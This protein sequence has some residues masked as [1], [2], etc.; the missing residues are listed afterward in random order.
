[1]LSAKNSSWAASW[2]VGSAIVVSA[3]G[4]S[5][6]DAQVLHSYRQLPGYDDWGYIS[7]SEERGYNG[8]NGL[9]DLNGINGQNGLSTGDRWDT[10]SRSGVSDVGQEASRA[11]RVTDS[12]IQSFGGA[13][14]GGSAGD[15]GGSDD[16]IR[17]VEPPPAYPDSWKNPPPTSSPLLNAPFNG[18]P[19][20]AEWNVPENAPM[21]AGSRVSPIYP[22][23]WKYPPLV[24]KVSVGLSS[25]GVDEPGVIVPRGAASEPLPLPRVVPSSA[26]V[27]PQRGQ[28]TVLERVGGV[29]SDT[30]GGVMTG[31]GNFFKSLWSF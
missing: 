18:P 27:E 15:D 22:P 24:E 10:A 20:N 3:T 11:G 8:Q 26:P 17:A 19:M 31:I 21:N 9:N 13:T 12:N 2:L 30:V 4:L 25:V 29:I 5:A 7:G 23:T 1:M 6:L 16:I 28:E 14:T